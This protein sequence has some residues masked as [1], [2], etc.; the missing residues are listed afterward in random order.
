VKTHEKAFSPSLELTSLRALPSL[1][2]PP[3]WFIPKSNHEIL[4][5]ILKMN[6][7]KGERYFRFKMIL[8]P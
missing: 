5:N 3:S 4:I 1:K 6:R 8:R 2:A 7:W